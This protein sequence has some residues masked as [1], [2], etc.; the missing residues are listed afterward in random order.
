MTCP[1]AATCPLAVFCPSTVCT[2]PVGLF[3]TS[4]LA[5]NSVFSASPLATDAPSLWTG[6]TTGSTNPGSTVK[7]KGW[8][9]RRG[10]KERMEVVQVRR[11]MPWPGSAGGAEV[12]V[13]L[14]VVMNG[15]VL[16]EVLS[17]SDLD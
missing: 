15:G 2:A 13:G 6:L 4:P 3:S 1:L 17:G 7:K 9:Q 14:S 10:N 5:V 8:S 11:S 16:C 12:K